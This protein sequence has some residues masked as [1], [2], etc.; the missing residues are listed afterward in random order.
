M[1]CGGASKRPAQ[2]ATSTTQAPELAEEMCTLH[3]AP[4]RG[5]VT[6][7]EPRR[8]SDAADTRR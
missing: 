5:E 2:G 1:R 8:Q 3:L 4:Q 7:A 6:G